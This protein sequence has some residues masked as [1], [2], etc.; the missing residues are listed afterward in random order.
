MFKVFSFR[1]FDISNFQSFYKIVYI[2]NFNKKLDLFK[3]VGDSQ[4][5]F[6]KNEINLKK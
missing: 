2:L 4:Q 3:F 1:M 5:T 6:V